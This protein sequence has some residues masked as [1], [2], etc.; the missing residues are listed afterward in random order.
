MKVR[1][2]GS[3]A[4]VEGAVLRCLSAEALA[5]VAGADAVIAKGQANYESL[6]GSGYPVFYIFMCKCSLFTERF[7]VP[8]FGGILTR[9]E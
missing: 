1:V 4:A 2:I 3:G 5:A 8:Q 9:E 6:G 7:G